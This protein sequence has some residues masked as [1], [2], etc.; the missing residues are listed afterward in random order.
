MQ[1]RVFFPQEVLDLWLVDG[2]VDLRQNELTLVDR[3]DPT[4]RPGRTYRVTEAVRVLSEVT[5]AGD[6][7]ELVGRVK[8]KT[9]LE[10]LGAEILEGSM[11]LGDNAYDVVPGWMG[12]SADEGA[13]DPG[14]DGGGPRD[15]ELLAGLVQGT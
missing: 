10:Q 8:A 2:R 14:A 7:H 6:P 4:G 15:E 9:F 13:G 3:E 5:G 1:N 11:I 12:V